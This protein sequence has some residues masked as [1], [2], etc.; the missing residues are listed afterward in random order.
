M[1]TRA[2]VITCAVAASALLLAACGEKDEPETTGPI[3]PVET[4]APDTTAT[5]PDTTSTSEQPRSDEDVVRA[6]LISPDAELVC[7]E[8][9][10]EKFLR[11]TYGDRSGCLSARKPATLATSV[12]IEPA[13][14][15]LTAEPRGGLY[16][17]DTLTFTIVDG[18]ID[19]I[20]SDAP[21]GP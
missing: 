8:L 18:A 14:G 4:T 20:E 3:V 5:S 16:D 1:S 21:V 10:T 9:V 7:D 11:A 6:F 19:S 17:G 12:M 13:Q 15:A 2:Q